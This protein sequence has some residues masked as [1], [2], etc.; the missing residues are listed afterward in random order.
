VFQPLFMAEG[1]A[2]IASL[3]DSLKQFLSSERIGSRTDDDVSLI[4]ATRRQHE[5][6]Q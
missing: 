6:F 2:E 1:G 3:S 4:L 5:K